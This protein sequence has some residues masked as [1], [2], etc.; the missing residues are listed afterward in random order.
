MNKA[1]WWKYVYLTITG[2]I[3]LALASFSLLFSAIVSPPYNS[4]A[5]S[6]SLDTLQNF[7]TCSKYTVSWFG[8]S[9]PPCLFKG[10]SYELLGSWAIFSPF[11]AGTLLVAYSLRLRSI[12]ANNES[13]R[14]RISLPDKLMTYLLSG[15]IMLLGSFVVFY[16]GDL[17]SNT[18]QLVANLSGYRL[19]G[20]L[21]TGYNRIIILLAGSILWSGTTGLLTIGAM[22]K[23]KSLVQSMLVGRAGQQSS[24]FD[25]LASK[26]SKRFLLTLFL[27]SSAI[28]GTPIWTVSNQPIRD[29]LSSTDPHG[30][31]SASTFFWQYAI[32]IIFL[33]DIGRMLLLVRI[34]QRIRNNESIEKIQFRV[35]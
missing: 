1:R 22:S 10:D 30:T 6:S 12:L 32:G 26:P 21:E 25:K 34:V 33:I 13:E 17:Y 31:H 29:Y 27:L 20:W 23:F 19:Q 9:G 8:Y 3:L 14:I 15:L 2:S 35:T 24:L 28:L 16:L 18:D 5:I 11:L 7:F 4:N